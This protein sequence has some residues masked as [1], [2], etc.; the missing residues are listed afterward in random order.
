MKFIL[1]EEESN[2]LMSSR[3]SGKKSCKC[4]CSSANL[5]LLSSRH[6]VGAGASEAILWRR[7]GCSW[8][9]LGGHRRQSTQ[10]HPLRQESYSLQ[11]QSNAYRRPLFDRTHNAELSLRLAR[12]RRRTQKLRRPKRQNQQ[13]QEHHTDRQWSLSLDC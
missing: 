6:S 11:R 13:R 2:A 7:R 1:S 10:K 12:T 3:Q 4:I 8:P 5:D 9:R